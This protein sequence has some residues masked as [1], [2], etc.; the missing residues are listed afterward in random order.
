[1]VSERR[2]KEGSILR[3]FFDDQLS[4][5]GGL[6]NNWKQSRK[7]QELEKQIVESVVDVSNQRLR[8]TPQYVK[9]LRSCA[10]RLYHHV[11][12]TADKLPGPTDLA[13]EAF[14]DHPLI[15]SL[16]VNPDDI[17]RFLSRDQEL[18]KYRK[19]RPLVSSIH[20]YLVAQKTIK[21]VLGSS[22]VDGQVVND[23]LQNTINFSAH[24]IYTPA[25]SSEEALGLIKSFLFEQIISS[26]S[27][28]LNNEM[29]QEKMRMAGKDHTAHINSLS[30]PSVYLRHLTEQL[31]HAPD[32]LSL[33]S[34]QLKVSKRGVLLDPADRQAANE[35][36]LYEIRWNKQ[37]QKVIVPVR[38]QATSG[39]KTYSSILGYTE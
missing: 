26:V 27:E 12:E 28:E 21:Q 29:K 3:S 20:G 37:L 39:Q 25:A 35:F 6:V 31:E 30:N 33:Q 16:F 15:N 9:A 17:T 1:M 7:R 18:L 34:S 22:L 36:D 13:P 4:Y 2:T 5:I 11:Q 14:S 8:S 19:D 23:V 10:V 38:C 32:L 24:K